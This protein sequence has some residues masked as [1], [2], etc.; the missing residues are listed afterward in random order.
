MLVHKYKKKYLYVHNKT[1]FNLLAEYGSEPFQFR[2]RNTAFANGFVTTTISI[3]Q[4]INRARRE[5]YF[6]LE[7]GVLIHSCALIKSGSSRL[8]IN[9]KKP[10]FFPRGPDSLL[11]LR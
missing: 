5:N 9:P 6:N 7:I 2:I 10:V 11:A 4:Q 1:G 3:R 8:D